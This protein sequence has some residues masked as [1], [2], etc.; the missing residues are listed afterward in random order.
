M[1]ARVTKGDKLA[2]QLLLGNRWAPITNTLSFINA[3]L[4]EAAQVWFDCYASSYADNTNLRKTE[5]S[6]SLVELFSKLLPLAAGGE[7]MFLETVDPNWTLAVNNNA[8]TGPDLSSM[9]K[10]E[11]AEKRGVRS[12]IVIETPHT[13]DRK[14]YPEE[15]GRYGS[16]RFL[17]LGP[18]DAVTGVYLDNEGK[19]SFARGG[20]VLDFEDID[21]Y[22]STLT[23]D[24]FTHDMLV[25]YCRHLG[26]DPFSEEF[27]VP[28]GRGIMIGFRGEPRPE[29]GYTLAEARAG[30]EDRTVPPIE[31]TL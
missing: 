22:T 18:G 24:R 25:D 28:N 5:L 1:P 20:T 26:L 10:L 19:W 16:R 11:Y 9:L 7:T 30:R 3:P 23:T 29:D 8:Y 27:Y 15:R 21:A 14:N 6:G 13:L 31:R 12:V 17:L 4:E 2:A